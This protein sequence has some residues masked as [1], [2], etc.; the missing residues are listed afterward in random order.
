MAAYM[1]A[2][3][4]LGVRAR[5]GRTYI[6]TRSRRAKSECRR[7]VVSRVAENSGDSAEQAPHRGERIDLE[8]IPCYALQNVADVFETDF[9][10]KRLNRRNSLFFCNN[11]ILSNR[12]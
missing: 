2:S 5:A 10:R 12:R 11:G 1:R 8:P 9:R 3:F 7:R 4:Q 6:R